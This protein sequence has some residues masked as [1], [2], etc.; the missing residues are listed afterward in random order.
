MHVRSK[1]VPFRSVLVVEE[2]KFKFYGV[3]YSYWVGATFWSGSKIAHVGVLGTLTKRGRWNG[4]PTATWEKD[5]RFCFFRSSLPCQYHLCI[6][7]D[8]P[9]TCFTKFVNLNLKDFITLQNINSVFNNQIEHEC[10]GVMTKMLFYSGSVASAI[11][12]FPMR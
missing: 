5:Y 3:Q 8:L 12:L 6:R 11:C 10:K 9:I 7:I 1:Y 4:N 2:L